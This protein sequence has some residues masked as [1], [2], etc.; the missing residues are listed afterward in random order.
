MTMR[1]LKTLSLLVVL[2][3]IPAFLYG[4]MKGLTHGEGNLERGSEIIWW[5]LGIAGGTIFLGYLVW[6]V[7][8]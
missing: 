4:A 2:S 8:D 6:I 5:S 1:A 3:C 7:R